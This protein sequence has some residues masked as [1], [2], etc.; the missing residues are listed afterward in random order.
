MSVWAPKCQQFTNDIGHAGLVCK[1]LTI[2]NKGSI[3]VKDQFDNSKQTSVF[4]V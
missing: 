4:L 1:R 2:H 3:Y